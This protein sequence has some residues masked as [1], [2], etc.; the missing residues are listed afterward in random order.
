MKKEIDYL[1]IYIKAH[2][3]AVDLLREAKILFDNSCYARA[4]ALA[5]TALE[6]ISKSQLAADVFT[7]FSKEQQ[8]LDTYTNHNLKR[9]RVRWAHIDANSDLYNT[10]WTG[11][12][13]DDIEKITTKKPSWIKRQRALYVDIGE[14]NNIV[15]PNQFVTLKDAEDI[16]H[17]VDVALKRIWEVTEY[18]GNQIGTK[19]FMK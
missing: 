13:I 18:G 9:K 15:S 16:I 6:E 11:P 5:Y 19:G 7:R 1:D 3:N 8:F 4:Y 2:R 12:D 17:I 14:K 10:I